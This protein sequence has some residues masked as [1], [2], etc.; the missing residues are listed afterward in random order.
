MGAGTAGWHLSLLTRPA[1]LSGS[2]SSQSHLLELGKK[3]VQRQLISNHICCLTSCMPAPLPSLKG[4][5]INITSETP[6]KIVRAC[7]FQRMLGRKGK[8][9]GTWSQCFTWLT[10]RRDVQNQVCWKTHKLFDKLHTNN[11]TGLPLGYAST[12]GTAIAL[13]K[14]AH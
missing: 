6:V 4:H 7:L 12:A 13:T 2:S 10:W 14:V 9:A 8:E 1:P 11:L 5:S 3:P